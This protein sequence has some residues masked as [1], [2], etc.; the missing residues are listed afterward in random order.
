MKLADLPFYSLLIFDFFG[1][2]FYVS[3]HKGK[4][5][6]YNIIHSTIT[7]I[8]VVRIR[9]SITKLAEIVTRE[10]GL[11][12]ARGTKDGRSQWKLGEIKNPYTQVVSVWSMSV[13]D[14]PVVFKT[15]EASQ[16]QPGRGPTAGQTLAHHF[17][18]QSKTTTS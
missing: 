10:R 8:V 17:S 9:K 12:L 4:C 14:T 2:G 18:C 13:S 11:E 1:F 6:L 15:G 7:A 16:G 3:G 5:S